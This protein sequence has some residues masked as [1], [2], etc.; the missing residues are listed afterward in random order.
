MA[1]HGHI[2]IE[3]SLVPCFH[4]RPICRIIGSQAVVHAVVARLVLHGP[5]IVFRQILHI[6]VLLVQFLILG[7]RAQN[8]L[9]RLVRGIV[10]LVQSADL[11]DAVP[12]SRQVH[13]RII[14]QTGYPAR[15]FC[16]DRVALPL[17]AVEFRGEALLLRVEHRQPA[18]HIF[19]RRPLLR[20]RRLGRA[21]A[22]R[23]R[24]NR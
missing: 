12:D 7:C 15:A 13:A 18:F 3:Q 20:L 17:P 14:G 23:D 11:R 19:D 6:A 24:R 9:P 16:Q 8:L 21:P 2:P 22:E 10:T 1:Q 5:G 4:R